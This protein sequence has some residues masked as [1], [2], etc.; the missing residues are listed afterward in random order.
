MINSKFLNTF[1][2]LVEVG[3]YTKTAKL[4]NMTQSG[5][6]QHID[7]LEQSIGKTIINN[8]GKKFELT[9]AGYLLYKYAIDIRDR[10]QEFVSEIGHDYPYEGECK[11]GCSGSI[12]I[13][14]YK[15][16]LEYQTK[17]QDLKISLESIPNKKIIDMLSSNDI[18]IGIV[19]NKQDSEQFTQLKVGVQ[20]LVVVI[21]KRQQDKSLE[22]IINTG[23]INHPDGLYYLE[24]IFKNNNKSHSSFKGVRETGYVNQLSQILLPVSLGLGF[25]ILPRFTVENSE[26][27]DKLKILDLEVPTYESIYVLYKKYKDLPVRY[28]WF[29][30]HLKSFLKK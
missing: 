16:F 9:Q 7:K 30:D 4:L 8:T 18:D 25:T 12:L 26:Y 13:Q 2:K 19:T 15:P 6:S 3:H 28:T 5:V 14:I 22:D 29:L 1:L 17:H 21:S 24:K 20:E 11:F 10:E 23:F 27:S